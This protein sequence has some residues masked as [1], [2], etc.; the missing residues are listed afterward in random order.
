M[1][2]DPT[3]GPTDITAPRWLPKGSTITADSSHTLGSVNSSADTFTLLT[4]L[5]TGLVVATA[6]AAVAAG[7]CAVAAVAARLRAD[8]PVLDTGLE[9]SAA[10]AS[11]Q[12][13]VSAVASDQTIVSAGADANPDPNDRADAPSGMANVDL[14]GPLPLGAEAALNAIVELRPDPRN[15]VVTHRDPTGEVRV[16]PPNTVNEGGNQLERPV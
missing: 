3:P 5:M 16:Y 13:I 10:V 6:M 12:T 15:V 9:T 7:V 1:G 11:E 4:W 14:R 2:L 8:A